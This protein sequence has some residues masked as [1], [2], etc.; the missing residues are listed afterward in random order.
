MRSRK[1]PQKSVLQKK[2]RGA[3]AS[4]GVSRRDGARPIII[5]I[6]ANK[7]NVISAKPVNFRQFWPML[8]LI[9][10]LATATIA[11]TKPATPIHSGIQDSAIGE[12][13]RASCRERV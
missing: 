10:E 9:T 4:E 8:R 5:M 6:I 12:I 2:Y 3:F 7:A 11:S 13:G 1:P